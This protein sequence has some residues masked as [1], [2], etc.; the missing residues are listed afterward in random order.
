MTREET[1]AAQ[2]YPKHG[3]TDKKPEKKSNTSS[4]IKKVGIRYYKC[5]ESTKKASDI[6]VATPATTKPKHTNK[7][8]KVEKANVAVENE[9]DEDVET[10]GC[11][12]AAVSTERSHEESIKVNLDT[13][14]T[15]HFIKDVY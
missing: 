13:G 12:L 8:K 15:N 5:G 1:Y 6:S 11:I 2:S 4:T 10:C 14:A 3:K 9:S 7:S